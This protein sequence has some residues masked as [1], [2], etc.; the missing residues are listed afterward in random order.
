M[1]MKSFHREVMTMK[2]RLGGSFSMPQDP[3]ARSL[4]NSFQ[5]LEDEVQMGKSVETIRNR[6]K[7]IDSQ[8]RPAHAAGVMNNSSFDNLEDWVREYIQKAR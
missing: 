5:K 4:V 6:L 1:D 7:E 2:Q 3:K 8:L